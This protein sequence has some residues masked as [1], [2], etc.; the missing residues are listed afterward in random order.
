MAKDFILTWIPNGEAATNYS[1]QYALSGQAMVTVLTGSGDPAYRLGGLTDNEIYQVRVAG[2]NT[3]GSGTYSETVYKYASQYPSA[4]LSL[5]SGAPSS[6][7]DLNLTWQTPEF[8]GD[9]AITEYEVV[10]T[11]SGESPSGQLTGNTNTSFNLTSLDCSKVHYVAVAAVNTA[12]SGLVASGDFSPYCGVPPTTTPAPGGGITPVAD[13]QVRF[14]VPASATSI[15]VNATSSTGYYALTDGTNTSAVRGFSSYAGAYYGYMYVNSPVV[16][17]TLVAGDRVVRLF[18][19]NAAGVY[20]STADIQAFSLSNN[21]QD[22]TAVDLS[23]CSGCNYAGMM[24][25]TRKRLIFGGPYTVSQNSTIAEVRAVGVTLGTAPQGTVSFYYAPGYT[26][27]FWLWNGGGADLR[28]QP[29][30]ASALNQL[31]TDLAADGG[32]PTLGSILVGGCTGAGSDNPSI[33]TGKGYT[34]DE[35]TDK[36]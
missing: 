22:V 28:D 35:T 31:Y 16:L 19:C 21:D 29:M 11:P 24:A 30:T 20:D 13:N 8:S 25:D 7:G 34:V 27:N 32:D 17:S 14:Y 6:S 2:I 23:H 4:P 12:G 1:V 5:A 9:T 26:P 36:E 15:S 10:Y 33:A 3:S 18:P